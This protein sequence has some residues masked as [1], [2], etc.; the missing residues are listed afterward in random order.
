MQ[1]KS[2][3]ARLKWWLF[4]LISFL[5]AVPILTSGLV[6]GW[7]AIKPR[8]I[9]ELKP[10]LEQLLTPAD[11][12]FSIQV[13]SV[14]VGYGNLQA[15]LDLRVTEVTLNN[16]E[17]QTVAVFPEIRVSL[18]GDALLQGKIDPRAISLVEPSMF[19]SQDRE[20][21]FYLGSSENEE[22]ENASI[23][24]RD[25]LR[26]HAAPQEPQQKQ[27]D[28]ASFQDVMNGKAFELGVDELRIERANIYL[29]S[30]KANLQLDIPSADIEIRLEGEKFEGKIDLYTIE[31]ANRDTSLATFFTYDP[32]SREV[33]LDM[34]VDSLRPR[35]L[36]KF[37]PKLAELQ[38]FNLP[39]SG[40]VSMRASFPDKLHELEMALTGTAGTIHH[41][42][43]YDSPVAISDLAIEAG[44]RNGIYRLDKAEARLD[45]ARLSSQAIVTETANAM[46]VALQATIEGATS[47]HI[48][49]YW[50]KGAAKNAREWVTKHISN[51]KVPEAK[52]IWN[53]NFA[54]S[55]GQE[56][57]HEID[58]TIKVRDAQLAY[59]LKK[60]S[61][62]HVNAEVK[63]GLDT[64]QA[65]I[66][67]AQ[68]FAD[69]LLTKNATVHIP[70]FEAEDMLI[71]IKLPVKTSASD[72]ASYLEHLPISM[73]EAVTLK[74][75]QIE[76]SLQ[77][78]VHIK[79]LDRTRP[80]EDQ[81][82]F[83]VDAQ[84]TD[85]GQSDITKDLS[86][87][88]V[89]GRLQASD[90][91]LQF[92]G[93]ANVNGHALTIKTDIANSGKAH[94]QIRGALPL[95]ELAGYG[96]DVSDYASGS[97]Y[98][99]VDVRKAG[100]NTPENIALH[101]DL[102][103]TSL[104]IPPLGLNKEQGDEAKLKAK[105]LRSSQRVEVEDFEL[106]LP[107]EQKIAG[108]VLFNPATESLEQLTLQ[109]LKVGRN[110]LQ[111]RYALQG[112]THQ[113][114]LE[115][116]NLDLSY[117]LQE[118]DKE[119]GLESEAPSSS[120][121]PW[122]ELKVPDL[123]ANIKLD[124]VY[125]EEGS[126]L[127]YFSTT[128]K[129][130]DEICPSLDLTAMAGE[131]PIYAQIMQGEKQREL[132]ITTPDA[133]KF[134]KKAGIFDDMQGGQLKVTGVYRDD[135][136]T[137]PLIGK[138]SVSEHRVK[139]VP[140]LAKLLT[141]ATFTGI[142]DSLS[143]EGLLFTQLEAPFK[144]EDFNL[145]LKQAKTYGPSIGITAEGAVHLK[146]NHIDVRGTVVPAYMF[147]NI[148]GQ[149]PF[150]GEMFSTIAGDGLVAMN[151]SIKG[152]NDETNITVNPLSALT[153]GFLRNFFNIFDPV[154]SEDKKKVEAA[155]AA[156]EEAEGDI[157]R[158]EDE[159]P[160]FEK[161]K[162]ASP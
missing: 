75:E 157:Q 58:S 50:P 16:R 119:E 85:I 158:L 142:V 52:I 101:A 63:V 13:G 14:F 79:V 130:M 112:L 132:K 71:D 15:P 25:M 127:S 103:N 72:L 48:A 9:V 99:N 128:L 36:A 20:G 160:D 129:C 123:S 60:P 133:G 55:E 102:K 33:I 42:D 17:H 49:R 113:L 100:K 22:S 108:S 83:T 148:L 162:N 64:L 10:Q 8:E 154:D 126:E 146:D 93:K 153:P 74:P 12:R 145:T 41:A 104:Q 7:I 73:P 136:P 5:V 134:F 6:L 11:G 82:S 69:N 159:L 84:A 21:E 86:V 110:N 37:S 95:K 31:E 61:L 114:T 44:Y 121:I 107:D 97:A 45:N 135:L 161:E 111:A 96:L 39:L 1:K 94:H 65:E 156:L 51:A 141:V 147:N 92:D 88:G 80:N 150:L 105:I 143:G 106:S 35:S 40:S 70:S 30:E 34:N 29:I 91:G 43:W 26:D 27:E 24:I 2:H 32:A 87:S 62:S 18:K 122:E 149:V 23:L 3:Y 47:K 4:A 138:L 109:P 116:K 76:G 117:W 57:S 53:G 46:R 152:N 54:K 137:R 67:K 125:L 28:A 68:L 38:G 90:E 118:E 77:G 151:Y 155:G 131:T 89:N 66:S 19:I 140:I 78:D 144:L 56:S 59:D 139:N 98:L 115:G 81:V 124:N 120:G